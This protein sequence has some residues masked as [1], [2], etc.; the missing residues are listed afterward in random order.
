MSPTAPALDVLSHHAGVVRRLGVDTPTAYAGPL[1]VVEHAAR[2]AIEASLRSAGWMERAGRWASFGKGTA[3]R[4]DV[5]GLG[6]LD[7]PGLAT[8]VASATGPD[9]EEEL[10][11]RALAAPTKGPAVPAAHRAAMHALVAQDS[12]VWLRAYRRAELQ[13]HGHRVLALQD[14]Y[15]TGLPLGVRP[16]TPAGHDDAVVVAL[17][18]L[19]GAGKTT[20]A[21]LLA[22]ALHALG[23]DVAVEW[24][25]LGFSDGLQRL[26]APVK[27]LA[28]V[29]GRRRSSRGPATPVAPDEDPGARRSGRRAL[30][31]DGPWSVLV[32]QSDAADARTRQARHAAAGRVAV[33]D[34]YLLDSLVHVSD[35]YG[36]GPPTAAARALLL[37]RMP[38]ATCAVLLELPAAV[39][40]ARK[41]GEW[42][43]ADL[44]R[45][46]RSY[47]EHAGAL[48]V[49]RVD[50][51]LP[52]HELAA[53]IA[54]RVWARLP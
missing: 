15:E 47:A 13:G 24:A 22:A 19:D 23:H 28:S 9:L 18:G 25:R 1:V 38:P 3:R 30:L 40:H 34:R 52:V 32:A 39:A 46:A 12:A 37:R 53:V 8:A 42:S 10:V 14:A 17:S 31:L 5:V 29:T 35:R 50:A 33:R 21:H 43:L 11:V 41:P 48:D 36:A 7:V 16:G 6:E 45:H 51:T 54:A 49:E 2:P 20:Q 27:R 44:E 26:A 4:L